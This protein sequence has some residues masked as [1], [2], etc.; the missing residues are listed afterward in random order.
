[1]DLDIFTSKKRDKKFDDDDVVEQP[2]DQQ[3][4]SERYSMNSAHKMVV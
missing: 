3:G 4:D 2:A 1:M